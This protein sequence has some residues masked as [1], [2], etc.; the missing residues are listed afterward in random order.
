MLE[1]EKILE[2]SRE[3][4]RNSGMVPVHTLGIA[5]KECR[6][7]SFIERGRKKGYR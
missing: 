6:D 4:C 5:C 1:K 2:V 3:K 7:V